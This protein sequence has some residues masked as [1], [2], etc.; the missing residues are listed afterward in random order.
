MQGV[1]G[2]RIAS[3]TVAD[4]MDREPVTIPGELT[5]LQA[6]DQFFLRYRWPWFV[7]VDDQRHFL[8]VLRQKR[9]DSEIAEGRPALRASEVLE[10]DLQ[11]SIQEDQ[12][13]ESLLRSEGLG[14]LGGMVAVDGDG[15][16]QGVVT[17]AQITRALRP[18]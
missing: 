15:V 10:Q 13:L 9:I 8:G 5:L 17:Q 1:F 16:L 4:I 2:Q 7:V 14:R 12:P 11:I 3:I 18:A 6:Q